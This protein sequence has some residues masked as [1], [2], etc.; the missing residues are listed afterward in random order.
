MS[1]SLHR[2]REFID[3]EST[4]SPG[5]DRFKEKWGPRTQPWHVKASR[6][7]SDGSDVLIRDGQD[8]DKAFFYEILAQTKQKGVVLVISQSLD[9]MDDHVRVSQS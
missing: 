6:V 9:M 7:V 8:S 2:I 1:F 3:A 5:I 4:D